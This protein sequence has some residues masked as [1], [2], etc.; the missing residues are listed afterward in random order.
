VSKVRMSVRSRRMVRHNREFFRLMDETGLSAD[1]LRSVL[2][3]RDALGRAIHEVVG[4]FAGTLGSLCDVFRAMGEN[5]AEEL[6]PL[7]A[8]VRE[9]Y[10]G[11]AS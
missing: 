11:D 7:V 4:A 2:A 3:T 5:L 6:A 1:Q 9:I 8:A 10:R